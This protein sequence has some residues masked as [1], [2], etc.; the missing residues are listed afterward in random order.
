MIENLIYILIGFSSVFIV[1]S[2]RGVFDTKLKQVFAGSS[3]SY[4]GF[5]LAENY[6]NLVSFYEV[7]AKGLLGL[8]GYVFIAGSVFLLIV[9]SSNLYQYGQSIR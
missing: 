6:T 8:G 3:F 5:T 2:A 1:M 4:G 9:W 7:A